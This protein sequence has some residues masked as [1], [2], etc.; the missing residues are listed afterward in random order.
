MT[1]KLTLNKIEV[2][3]EQWK[4]QFKSDTDTFLYDVTNQQLDSANLIYNQ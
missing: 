3:D 1:E 4:T 2:L